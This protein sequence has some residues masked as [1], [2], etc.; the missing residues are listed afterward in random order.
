[1]MIYIVDN[2]LNHR[3][4]DHPFESELIGIDEH[5]EKVE[6]ENQQKKGE[7]KEKNKKEKQG[8]D[9]EKEFLSP[10]IALGL[11]LAFFIFLCLAGAFS[12]IKG[13]KNRTDPVEA[14]SV[15]EEETLSFRGIIAGLELPHW[16]YCYGTFFVLCGSLYF[17]QG[18][19]GSSQLHDQIKSFEYKDKVIL[20]RS[21]KEK[22][23]ESH[24]RFEYNSDLNRKEKGGFLLAL[25]VMVIVFGAFYHKTLKRSK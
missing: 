20:Y 7:E 22:Q 21:D 18:H 8:K 3:L 1:M 6:Q 12:Y 14:V 15:F 17:Y 16:F 4:G 5:L 11:S 19:Q 13:K 2:P 25:G 10:Q 9:K 23:Y 24:I